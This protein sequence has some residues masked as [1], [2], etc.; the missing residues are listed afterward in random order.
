MKLAHR[1]LLMGT[2]VASFA[3]Q[4]LLVYTDTTADVTPPLEGA[5][6]RGRR[7][8]LRNNCQ[9]CHQIYGFGG[10]LGPDL[11]NAAS[12]LNRS[13]LDSILTS[14]FGQMPAFHFSADQISDLEAYLTALDATGV[15]QARR[16]GTLDRADIAAVIEEHR[17][18]QPL[19][20]TAAQGYARFSG[21]CVAC[22]VLFQSTP[23]GPNSA[24]DLSDV[25]KRMPRQEIEQV[26]QTGR[27]E[28]GMPPFGLPETQRDELLH[29]LE[30]VSQNRDDLLRRS[31]SRLRS[32][33]TL[34]WFEFK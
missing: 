33:E 32:D 34:P 23:L 1:K 17:A 9:T 20:Q 30:W 21:I 18:E 11:T 24:P 13:R 5:A 16:Q 4:T 26:L 10:F 31:R 19:S 15:G 27:I 22:H 12:R 7:I 14:G 29:F 8:W 3:F 28:R 2:L 6:L 25:I